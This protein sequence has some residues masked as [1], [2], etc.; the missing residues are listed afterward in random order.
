MLQ[1]MGAVPASEWLPA[2][3]HRRFCEHLRFTDQQQAFGAPVSREMFGLTAS[4]K[5]PEQCLRFFLCCSVLDDAHAPGC[6]GQCRL[7]Y[8]LGSAQQRHCPL[9]Q[10]SLVHTRHPSSKRVKSKTWAAH[11]AARA[12]KTSWTKSRQ[13]HGQSLRLD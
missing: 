2:L 9:G 8:H 5:R 6:T 10:S 13:A 7:F 4:D 12:Q 11:S 3:L 1:A